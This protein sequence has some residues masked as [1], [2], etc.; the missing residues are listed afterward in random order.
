VEKGIIK[1]YDSKKGFGFIKPFL[2][3][4]DVFLHL[5]TVK[6]AGLKNLDNN[7]RVAYDLDDSKNSL[8]AINLKLLP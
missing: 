1:Y 6:K 4:G 2:D 8:V 7:Q 5:S 3:N